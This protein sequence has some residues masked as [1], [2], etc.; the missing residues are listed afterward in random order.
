MSDFNAFGTD[1]P[2]FLQQI[3]QIF[4]MLVFTAG[5]FYIVATNVDPFGGGPLRGPSIFVA[6]CL[7]GLFLSQHLSALIASYLCSIILPNKKKKP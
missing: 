1:Q 3:L 7:G 5:V 2:S 4:L 6:W